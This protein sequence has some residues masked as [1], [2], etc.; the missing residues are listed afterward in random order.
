MESYGIFDLPNTGMIKLVGNSAKIIY[1][2]EEH[3]S[4]FTTKFNLPSFLT[5]YLI[6]HAEGEHN[7]QSPLKRIYTWM[8]DPGLTSHG[9]NQTKK[10]AN[11]I[12]EFYKPSKQSIFFASDLH[13]AQ[14]TARIVLSEL[15]IN[16]K[17]RI[18]PNIGEVIFKNSVL[19]S[20]VS[21]FVPENECPFRACYG[22]NYD[23]LDWKLY[24]VKTDKHPFDFIIQNLIYL[25]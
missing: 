19:E 14:E 25:L 6:R 8:R 1:P 9:I 23:Y 20:I 22:K 5:I 17:I 15:V 2:Q 24:F 16:N 10:L 13:R 7:I 4:S 18:L 11:K 21:P 3:S 12:K